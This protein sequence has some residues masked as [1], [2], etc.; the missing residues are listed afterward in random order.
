[1]KAGCQQGSPDQKIS[2]LRQLLGQLVGGCP[3]SRGGPPCRD[4]SLAMY[5]L[6]G[7]RRCG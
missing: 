5:S 4:L 6:L 3:L 7:V 2:P 1:M